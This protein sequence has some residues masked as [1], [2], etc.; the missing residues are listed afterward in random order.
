MVNHLADLTRV[1]S[2]SRNW[3]QYRA[4]R[5]TVSRFRQVLHTNPHQPSL[6]LL[7]SICYPEIH[8]FSTNKLSGPENM[9]K[10]LFRPANLRCKHPT[11]TLLLQMALLSASITH[12]LVYHHAMVKCKCCGLGVAE[13]MSIVCARILFKQAARAGNSAWKSNTMASMQQPC[14]PLP[15]PAANL[16]DMA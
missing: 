8:K 16:C 5:I 7:K 3:F 12:I 13:V 4:V 2:E 11:K 1:H 15:V 6:S 9:R 14:V 10:I